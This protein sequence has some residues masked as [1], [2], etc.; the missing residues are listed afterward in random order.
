MVDK[1][2]TGIKWADEIGVS[3][4]SLAWTRTV[5]TGE[6]D[7]QLRLKSISFDVASCYADRGILS[8]TCFHS[9]LCAWLAC[10]LNPKG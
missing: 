3:Y 8:A 4:V 9:R 6:C 5:A 1:S 7:Y 10:A 2:D